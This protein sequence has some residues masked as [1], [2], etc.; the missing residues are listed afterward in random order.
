MAKLFE[1]VNVYSIHYCWQ[2]GVALIEGLWGH[3]KT[4]KYGPIILPD[5][6]VH[7]TVHAN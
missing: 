7:Q 2:D 1:I 4:T 6:N 3:P 5:H